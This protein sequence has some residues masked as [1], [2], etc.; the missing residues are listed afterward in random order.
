MP[1]NGMTLYEAW[2]EL[3]AATRTLLWNYSPEAIFLAGLLIG[4]VAGLLLAVVT[5]E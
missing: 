4:I 1:D 2:S 5:F 3:C